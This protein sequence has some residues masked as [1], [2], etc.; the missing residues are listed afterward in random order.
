MIQRYEV[1]ISV[2]AI[3]PP[4]APCFWRGVFDLVIV[5]GFG[6]FQDKCE[7]FSV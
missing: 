7:R 5:L 1:A 6:L 3:H 4:G 2:V